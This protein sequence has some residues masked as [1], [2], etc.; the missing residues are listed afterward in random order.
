MREEA[1][2]KLEL[3]AKEEVIEEEEE[4]PQRRLRRRIGSRHPAATHSRMG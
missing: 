4:A 3:P 2:G 1:Q